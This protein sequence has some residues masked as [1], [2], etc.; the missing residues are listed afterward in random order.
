MSGFLSYFIIFT[1]ILAT[2]SLV[3]TSDSGSGNCLICRYD[4]RFYDA[5]AAG[6][7]ADDAC[8]SAMDAIGL[9]YKGY[10]TA[11]RDPQGVYPNTQFTLCKAYR[12][13]IFFFLTSFS[14]S[15]S[16][17]STPRLL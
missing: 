7:H 16:S 15:C 11:E 12:L 1:S 3:D 4:S 14:H 5:T 8:A 9:S 10:N 6:S 17:G 2:L 13:S